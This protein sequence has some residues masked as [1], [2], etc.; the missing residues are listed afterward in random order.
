MYAKDIVKPE[1]EFLAQVK[2]KD[3]EVENCRIVVVRDGSTS[4]IGEDLLKLFKIVIDC[5]DSWRYL[6]ALEDG[7]GDLN[8]LLEKYEALFKEEL[9]YEWKNVSENTEVMQD[10]LHMLDT[11]D[12]NVGFETSS[13]NNT[14]TTENADTENDSRELPEEA[15]ESS[16]GSACSSKINNTNDSEGLV[17]NRIGVYALNRLPYGTKPACSIFQEG[18]ERTLQDAKGTINFIHNV[19]VTEKSGGT[20]KKNLETVLEKLSMAGF[21]LNLNKCNLGHYV[22]KEGLYKDKETVRAMTGVSTPNDKTEIKAFGYMIN[23]YSKFVP[24]LSTVLS[25]LYKLLGKDIH[26]YCS[27]EC[28]KAFIEVKKTIAFDQ[29]LAH[30]DTNAQIK[31]VCDVSKVGLGAVLLH[32]YADSTEKPISFASRILNK[33]ELN[34]SAIHKEALAIYSDHKPLSVLFSKDKGTEERGADYLSRFPIEANDTLEVDFDYFD[35]E[36]KDKVPVNSEQLRKE[37]RVNA[38]LSQ[39]FLYTTN[40]WPNEV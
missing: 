6:N 13:A 11:P 28:E 21:R 33:A 3:I 40:G 34:Y 27:R 7:D 15:T 32:V 10:A 23:Y 19:V 39:V 9:G 25:P 38:V 18:F 31:L 12:S 17:G 5:D 26:F 1:G 4:I 14:F 24:N 8:I 2:Y 22:D 29:S 30:F 35:C 16:I 37:I 20:F 36:A